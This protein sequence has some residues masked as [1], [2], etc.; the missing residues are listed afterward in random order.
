[1]SGVLWYLC[2]IWA[3]VKVL[4]NGVE[5]CAERCEAKKIL[6]K[7]FRVKVH[8]CPEITENIPLI[9]HFGKNQV[10]RCVEIKS[11]KVI[12]HKRRAGC[13]KKF[14]EGDFYT[15]IPIFAMQSMPFAGACG[16]VCA[17]S[18]SSTGVCAATHPL[19]RRHPLS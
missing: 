7:R 10:G 5:I 6:H 9:Q 16:T 17:P 11:F 18:P 4:H 12:M 1:M 3:N 2:R 19:V 13:A 15:S 8:F 14:R